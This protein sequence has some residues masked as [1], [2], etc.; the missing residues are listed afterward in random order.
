MAGV[1]KIIVLVV[2]LVG[3]FSQQIVTYLREFGILKHK[4]NSLPFQ[5]SQFCN[6]TDI[7]NER[8]TH[9]KC[10]EVF[11]SKDYFEA[12]DR[13]RALIKQL[14]LAYHTITL[15]NYPELTID[16]ALIPGLILF[17]LLFF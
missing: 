9:F 7:V 12:R 6:N 5:N 11:F 15:S 16:I 3:I 2:I 17:F 13:F 1:N 14:N 10:G 4:V 8:M